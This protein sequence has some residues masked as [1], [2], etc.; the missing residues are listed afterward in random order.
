MFWLVGLFELDVLEHFENSVIH[1]SCA[2]GGRDKADAA[3]RHV[4]NECPFCFVMTL[5]GQTV[6]HLPSGAACGQ[7][8]LCC[9]RPAAA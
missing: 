9:P 1:V 8:F 7:V 6:E 3:L 2:E 4:G 5:V